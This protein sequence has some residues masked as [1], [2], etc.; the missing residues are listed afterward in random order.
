MGAAVERPD[1]DDFQRHAGGGGGEQREH[2]AEHKT[3]GDGREGR[4]EIGA[5][6]VERAVR[7]VDQIHDAEDQRQP[8]GQQK[9]QHSELHAVETLLDEVEHLFV[10]LRASRTLSS[11]AQADDPVS[12]AGAGRARIDPARAEITGCPACAG[13]DSFAHFI[14]HWAWYLS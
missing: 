7:Q 10:T 11:S 9:Q 2:G 5:Q 1:G 13:H 4:G 12:A 3:A 14:G 6:H 8:G